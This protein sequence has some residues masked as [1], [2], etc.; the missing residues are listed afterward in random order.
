MKNT[1][2]QQVG[3]SFFIVLLL[4]AAL[5]LA[6]GNNL[7]RQQ[8]ALKEAN[9]H[10]LALSHLS[11]IDQLLME[12]LNQQMRAGMSNQ[13][14]VE[15]N[16][17]R[18]HEDIAVT[19]RRLK[20]LKNLPRTAHEALDT[21][22]EVLD[23]T[24]MHVA[25]LAVARELGDEAMA[26]EVARQIQD[27]VN[28][29]I[30]LSE[31]VRGAVLTSNEAA[32]Q[33]RFERASRDFMLLLA[34]VLVSLVVT[35]GVGLGLAGRLVRPV[36]SFM[37]VTNRIREGDYRTKVQVP[38]DAPR[39]IKQ[40]A[41][42][43]FNLQ[44]NLLVQQV[45]R[46]EAERQLIHGAFHDSLTGLANRALLFDRLN[47]SM[48]HARRHADRFFA[49]LYL[50]L[51]RFKVVN[52]SL[53]HHYGDKL[54]VQVSRRLEGLL[55]QN[56]TLARIGGDEFTILLDSVKTPHDIT[57]VAGRIQYALSRPYLIEGKEVE[58][59]CSMGVVTYSKNYETAEEM[60]R[61][62]DIA[63]Y[64]AK[65]RGRSRFEVF[66]AA[67]H[68]EQQRLHE[69]EI[70]LRGALK[71]RELEVHYQ[72]VVDLKTGAPAGLEALCR[73]KNRKGEWISP[74]VFIP[75][76]EETGLINDIGRWVLRQT[77]RDLSKF[78]AVMGDNPF[79]V[80]VNLSPRQLHQADLVAQV[81][82]A[83][84][85]GNV[86]PH[87]L[88]LEVTESAMKDDLPLFRDRLGQ[89]KELGVKIFL[90]DFGTGYSALA[91]LEGLPVDGLKVDRSFV[92]KIQ[93]EHADP[94]IV[95]A[96]LTLA[97]ALNLETVAEGIETPR[98]ALWLKEKG[99]G[100]GQGF[101]FARPVPLAQ[102]L[103]L[104]K[105]KTLTPAPR[106]V[107]ALFHKGEAAG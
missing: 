47:W 54:L 35:V 62:A 86:P 77:C 10:L 4:L 49:L 25:E 17:R 13:A 76:A 90:D 103:K 24:P 37:R 6:T 82:D 41:G 105:Q 51:D 5:A 100:M 9:A 72:P 38:H 70:E 3:H 87:A 91:H 71:R 40:L 44:H 67:M 23:K 65:A 20:F 11:E 99:C 15:T 7:M 12:D 101:Y 68:Q 60:L 42:S 74:T 78:L 102:A 96:V 31:G 79:W 36:E 98:Q 59:S 107:T 28:V 73:W 85:Q 50:D 95:E 81:K 56:D 97:D 80:S 46:E 88:K 66:D 45:K 94:A 55:R 39:E 16:I 2:R 22:Q 32:N 19:I 33:K 43:L 29:V 21:L 69:I 53:G 83:L 52:D 30:R 104:I 89:I 93:A 63:L 92:L 14:G 84:R 61:D 75:V 64:R 27:D 1:L 48:S 34:L 57:L 18:V 106:K 26:Q 58:T 8:G